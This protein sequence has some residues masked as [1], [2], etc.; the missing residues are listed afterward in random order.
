MEILARFIAAIVEESKSEPD[1]VRS[2][3]VFEDA[4]RVVLHGAPEPI[5][6]AES[7]REMFPPMVKFVRDILKDY[8]NPDF[9]RVPKQNEVK[10]KE[11]GKARNGDGDGSG[12]VE[13]EGN[14]RENKHN[15]DAEMGDREMASTDV[16]KAPKSNTMKNKTAS[17]G[18]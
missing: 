7:D 3:E 9:V 17:P 13:M 10:G 16:G 8:P 12:D 11:S 6:T 18:K 15:Q 5:F 4:K 2:R 1:R 14:E